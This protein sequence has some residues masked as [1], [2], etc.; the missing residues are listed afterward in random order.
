MCK[1]KD[2]GESVKNIADAIFFTQDVCA[3]AQTS[4]DVN[5]KSPPRISPRVSQRGSASTCLED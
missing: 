5:E 3:L 4:P 1:G 2:Q